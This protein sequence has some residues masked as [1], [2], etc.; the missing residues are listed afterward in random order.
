M[1]LPQLQIGKLTP[2]YPIIQGGMAVRVSTAPLAA[3]V[4]N[5]GGIGIIGASGMPPQELRDEIRSARKMTSGIVGV[6]IMYAKIGRASW[7]E[8]V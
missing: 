7:R 8:R 5:A 3:A 6:N 4:A 1:K 2:K